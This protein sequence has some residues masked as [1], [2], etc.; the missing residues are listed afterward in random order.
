[1]FEIT[2]V[3]YKTIEK[4]KKKKSYFLTRRQAV[5]AAKR[6]R[7]NFNF[8]QDSKIANIQDRL[9]A[10]PPGSLRALHRQPAQK[11]TS[12]KHRPNQGLW[13]S[14]C[15]ETSKKMLQIMSF[16]FHFSMLLLF[17][18]K[19]RV[20]FF[21]VAALTELILYIFFNRSNKAK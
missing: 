19:S 15:L 10:S 4:S 13:V 9:G 17:A 6:N 2:E 8:F 21:Y 20:Y 5:F 12:L 11:P 3:N 16:W 14:S 18:L 7:L 1:M